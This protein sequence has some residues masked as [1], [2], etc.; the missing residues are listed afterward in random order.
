MLFA[1]DLK[2]TL[3]APGVACVVIAWGLSSLIC[4]RSRIRG[5]HLHI[6][7]ECNRSVETQRPQ[8]L[9]TES[10]TFFSYPECDFSFSLDMNL[11]LKNNFL[12]L[13]LWLLVGT[14]WSNNSGNVIVGLGRDFWSVG[15]W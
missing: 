9:D 11:I 13:L 2:L 4:I 15:L 3:I 10:R 1:S 6:C 7:S 5:F 12:S 14:F 8:C